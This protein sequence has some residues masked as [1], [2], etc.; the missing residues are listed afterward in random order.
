MRHLSIIVGGLFILG[1]LAACSDDNDTATTTEAP[2]AAEAP[3]TTDSGNWSATCGEYE[4]PDA[5]DT[6]QVEAICATA[7]ALMEAINTYDSEALQAVTTEDFTYQTTGDPLTR[8]EFIPYF[9]EYY[10]A[11]NFNVAPTGPAVIVGVVGFVTYE[12]VEPGEV[13]SEDYNA[14]G[15]STY[16]VTGLHADD[17]YLVDEFVWT[18][19]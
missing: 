10:E 2:V 15:T 9:E 18:E 4:G 8:D 3:A 12:I 14:T 11:G 13:T 7:A 1:A 6:A 5:E 19:D 16:V 17:A